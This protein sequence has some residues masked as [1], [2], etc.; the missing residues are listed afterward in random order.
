MK[1][2]R[3]VAMMASLAL[4]LAACSSA[5]QPVSSGPAAS[6]FTMPAFE[7]VTLSNGLTLMLM[8]RY[9]VPLITVNAVVRA[10]SVDDPVAGLASLTAASLLLGNS[11]Q[12]KAQTELLVDS[13]GASL[14]SDAGVEGSVL[15]AD[16]MAKDADIMLPLIKAVLLEPSFDR[17]EFAKL[18]QRQVA[19]LQRAKE[20]PRAVIGNYFAAQLFGDH[21]YG[22]PSSGDSQSV[23][24]ISLAQINAFYQRHYQPQNTA[25]TI[26]GD[27]DPVKMKAYLQSLFGD[28]RNEPGSAHAAGVKELGTAPEPQQPRVLLVDKPDATETTFYIGG[29]GIRRDN[30]DYV[31]VQVINTVLGG[32]FTSWLNDELRVNSGL[33]YGAGSGFLPLSQ[34]GAFRIST[35]TRTDATAQAIDLALKTYARLWQQGIDQAT[36]DSAKAYVKGQFPPKFETSG[37]LAGLMADMYLYGFDE[38]FINSFEARVNGLTVADAQRLINA[39][40]PKDNLQFVLIG[41]AGAIAPI[42]AQYGDVRLVKMTAPGFGR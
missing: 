24:D 19:S 28:W 1:K 22:N 23:A 29:K 41:N 7:K 31:G 42:A 2:I 14:E 17:A 3:Q 5:P 15:S 21:P 37:Q 26:A 32:R 25:I 8:P 20:S 6:G 35:F 33:T 12:N 27:F 9:E 16:F 4:I 39:Y 40:F 38:D 10:G 34:D 13:L 30:P 18:Q 11:Q 36:L